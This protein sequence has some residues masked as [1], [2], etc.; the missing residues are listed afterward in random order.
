MNTVIVEG[1]D[2]A[3]QAGTWAEQNTKGKWKFDLVDMFSSNYYFVFADA[4]DATH[5]ALKWR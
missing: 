5:F 1:P 2:R 4:K 3:I